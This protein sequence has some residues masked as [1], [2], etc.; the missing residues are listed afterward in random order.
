MINKID[1]LGIA[2]HSLDETVKY[3]EEALG[4]TCEHREEVESQKVR[5]AFFNVGGTHI[6]L[7]EPT[8]PESP[9][10]KFLEKNPNGGIHHVA[11]ATDDIMG[12]L[13]KAKDA[14]VRLLNET[15]M[16][17]AHGKQ[18]A[19]LHPKSTFGVL[20]EFCSCNCNCNH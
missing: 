16:P 14:G 17:G 19:F 13:A 12:Q 8:S 4:L 5:V 3:Y 15:P 1:H 6:E 9:I 2:V 18:V 10:A 20:T 11:Y 7:L